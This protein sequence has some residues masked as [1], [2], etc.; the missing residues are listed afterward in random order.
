MDESDARGEPVVTATGGVTLQ[1]RLVTD[2]FSQPTVLYEFESQRDHA[3]AVRVI[4]PIPAALEPDDIGFLGPADERHWEINGPKL[5]FEH[6]LDPGGT[7]RTGVAARGERAGGIT[8]LL[9]TP[10][11][12]DVER[13]TPQRRDDDGATSVDSQD[14]EGPLVERL[15]SEL[16]EGT[17]PAETV[18]A[19]RAE[20]GTATDERHS[21]ETRLAQLQTDVADVRAY[22]NAM[23]AF[24]DELGPA[25]EVIGRLDRRLD[26]VDDRIAAVEKR[27]SE[28]GEE[29][30]VLAERTTRIETAI[31][32]LTADL[33]GVE[34]TLDRLDGTVERLEREVPADGDR[35]LEHLE[36]ELAEVS[37]FTTSLKA[38]FRQ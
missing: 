31:E 22:A 14:A 18:G 4:E 10:E 13:A 3:V 26:D 32:G 11:F 2:E 33:E 36:S 15:V 9:E 28:Q 29:I 30:E 35:R 19:L 17:V 34:A 8:D 24:I 27:V 1:K 12:L 20:L 7:Y 37:E 25:D 16:R 6:T 38:A 23:E 21:L 5:V